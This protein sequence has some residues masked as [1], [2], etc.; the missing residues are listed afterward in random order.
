VCSFCSFF[1]LKAPKIKDTPVEDHLRHAIKDL[2]RTKGVSKVGLPK[3]LAKD[4]NGTLKIPYKGLRGRLSLQVIEA[5]H[6]RNVTTKRHQALTNDC[7]RLL[8]TK[9]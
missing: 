5:H 4:V 8:R 2:L 9:L 3:V 7:R 6:A 1:E